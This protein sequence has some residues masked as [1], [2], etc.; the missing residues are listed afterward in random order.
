M[1]DDIWEMM[2]I[3]DAYKKYKNAKKFSLITSIALLVFLALFASV[4]LPLTSEKAIVIFLLNALIALSTIYLANIACM[5]CL[6]N[7]SI[8]IL[9]YVDKKHP[10]I[11]FDVPIDIANDIKKIKRENK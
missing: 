4:F 1:D 11:L 8:E 2:G 3:I 10:D 7:V 5:Q 6:L 9:K